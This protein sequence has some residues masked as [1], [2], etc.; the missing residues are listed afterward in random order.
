M[1]TLQEIFEKYKDAENINPAF[2]RVTLFSWNDMLTLKKEIESLQ[3]RL[4]ACNQQYNE[5]AGRLK[6]G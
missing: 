3:S 4:A 6:R 1:S 5:I 2:E